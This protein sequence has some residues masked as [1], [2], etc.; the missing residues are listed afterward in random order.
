MG[1]PAGERKKQKIKRRKRE[2]L[3]LSIRDA[4]KPQEKPKT[5]H[6]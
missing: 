3:R 1:N 5:D 2:E 4:A 6:K